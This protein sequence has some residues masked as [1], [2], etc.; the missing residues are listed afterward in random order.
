MARSPKPEKFVFLN[1]AG[2]RPPCSA[3]QN[4]RPQTMDLVLSYVDSSKAAGVIKHLE[5]ESP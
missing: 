1:K 5:P 3:L 2:V 4:E